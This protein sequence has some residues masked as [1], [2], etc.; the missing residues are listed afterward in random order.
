M[1]KQ[2]LEAVRTLCK[3]LG[4]LKASLEDIRA[5]GGIKSGLSFTGIKGNREDCVGIIIAE[6]EEEIKKISDEISSE[7]NYIRKNLEK[8]ILSKTEF[9]V[10]LYRYVYCMKWEDVAKC[11]HV[12][13]ST[14]KNINTK[15]LEWKI[16]KN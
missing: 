13:R 12:A 5:T 15:F 16:E 2:E 10:L 7:Q 6:K 11:A 8:M 14:A 4:D 9:E 3:R 1:T